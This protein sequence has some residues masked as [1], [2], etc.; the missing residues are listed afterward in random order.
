MYVQRI[1]LFFGF[2]FIYHY[3]GLQVKKNTHRFKR[4]IF[5]MIGKDQKRKDLNTLL[6]SQL[7]SL[8]QITVNKFL[9]VENYNNIIFLFCS[10]YQDPSREHGG[11]RNVQ[12]CSFNNKP[13]TG[14][15]CRVPLEKM[16]PCDKRHYNYDKAAPCIF[17]KLNRVSE[18]K[19]LTGHRPSL[20]NRRM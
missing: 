9:L 4:K 18:W 12:N 17:L 3:F 16:S 10:A 2:I 14:K 15:A 7:T 13:A 5:Y 6:P 20:W 11:G 1:R 19:L 8:S